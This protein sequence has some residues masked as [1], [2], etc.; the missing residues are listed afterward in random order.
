MD[1]VNP[2]EPVKCSDCGTWWRGYTHRCDNSSGQAAVT[3][4]G[5]TTGPYVLTGTLSIPVQ[6]TYN[7]SMRYHP[8]DMTVRISHIEGTPPLL[9]DSNILT[10]YTNT[11][12]YLK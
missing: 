3:T 1:N 5:G 4:G 11:D 10:V 7:V 8:E 9:I 12:M 6:D 2:N